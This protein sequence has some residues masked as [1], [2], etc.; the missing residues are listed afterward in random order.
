MEMLLRRLLV[1]VTIALT[2]T[3]CDP[4]TP[5]QTSDTSPT[6]SEQI[7]A[8]WS[9]HIAD[10]PKRWVAA[11]QPMWVRFSHPVA[12]EG[13]LNR[14]IDDLIQ[15]TPKVAITATFTAD[16]E[17]RIAPVGRLPNEQALTFSL[18][19]DKLQDVDP[20]L[21]PFSFEVHT[22]RQDFDLKLDSLAMQDGSEGMMRLTGE[23]HTTDTAEL[24]QVQKLVSVTVNG[25]A[26]ELAWTQ[27]EDRKTNRFML[28]NIARGEQTGK[29]RVEWDGA[30]IGSDSKGARD[31]SLPSRTAFVVTG[32]RVVRAQETYIE[33]NFSAPLNRQQNLA[34]LVTFNQQN[35]QLRVDG[36]SLRVYPNDLPQE[37]TTE[38]VELVISNLVLNAN[39]LALSEEFRQELVLALVQP[40]VNFVGAD[41][42][43]LPPAAQLSVPF[44][45]AGVDSVQVVAFKVYENNIG[46]YLQR[47]RLSASYADQSA[48]RYL[49]RKVY[50]LPDIPRASK[51]RF[52]LD[53]T[54]LMAQHPDGLLRVEL[55]IDR[56]NSVFECAGERPTEPESAA[57]EN[58]EGEDYY[59]REQPPAW[60][61]QYYQSGGYYNYSERTNPCHEAYYYYGNNHITARTFMVSNIGLLAKR[62]TDNVLQVVATGLNDAAPLPGTQIKAFNFQQQVI[63]EGKTDSYGMAEIA[64]DGTPFYLLAEHQKSRG[65]LRLPRNEALPTNQF[66]VSGEHVKA[67]LKGFIYGERDVWRPGD[68]IHLTFILQDREARIPDGHPVR[69]DFFDPRGN[70]ITSQTSVQPVNDF[71]TFTLK[72]NEDSPTG[73]WRAVV[74]V[75]NRFFDKIIKVETI[76]PNR[77]KVELTPAS[78]PLR[79][80]ELPMSVA[81]FGQ[82]LH[83]ATASGLKADSEVKL[84]SRK[85]QF[86]GFQQFVFDDP[87]RTFEGSSQKVFEGKLDREGKAS[88]PLDIT[89]ESPPPGMLTALFNTR[90]FEDSGNFSTALRAFEFHP[91][92]HWVGLQVPKGD[93]YSDAISREAD[94]PVY[95]Q[96]LDRDGKAAAGR[97][98]EVTVHAIGWRWWWDDS[99]DDLASYV[100][101]QH[102]APLSTTKLVT[103]AQGKASWTLTK[104]T[105]D[106]G[107]HL[108]RVC[109]TVSDHCS[110]QVVYLGWSWSEQ[111]NPESATQLMLTTDREK[112][113]VGDTAMVRLPK[114]IE[115]RALLSLE[116]GSRVL[117]RRWVD[118]P[119]GETEL[120]IPIT[121]AMAPNVYVHITLLLP[122]QQ[123]ATDAPMRLY[124]IV[125]LLVEDPA[126]RLQPQL[127]VPEKV[128][129][130]TEF[131]IRVSEE[132]KRA[133]T[134]TLALVDE[135]LLGLT[136]FKVPDAHSHFYRREALG[137]STWDLF[138]QVVGAYGASLE[139]VLAI[140]GSDAEQ[141]ADRQRRERRF[142]PIVK[143]LGT[144][145]LKAGET[146]EHAVTLPPYMGAVRVMLVAA[147]NTRATK[148]SATTYA[149]GKVEQTVTVTQPLVLLATLPRVVGPGEEVRLPVNVFVSEADLK[150]VAI[151]VE[152]NEIFTVLDK[153]AELSFDQPGDAITTLR[154]KVNDR[155]GKG[156]VKITARS[157][158]ESATQE[159]Y[160]DSRAAN[161]PSVVWESKLLDAGEVWQSPLVAHGMAGTNS[162]SVEVSTLPP[163]NLERRLEYLVNYPHGCLEQTTSAAFP[164]LYLGKLLAL[165]D[166]QKRDID[167]HME[168]AVKKLRSLQQSGG[169][170]SY[171]PGD[172]YVNDW[173]S[174]YAGHFLLEAKRAGYAVPADAL[175]NWASYQQQLVRNGGS[176]PVEAETT[177]AAYRL[178]TLALADKAELPAMNRLRERLRA[179]AKQPATAR[180]LLSMTYQHLGLKDAASD[181]LGPLNDTLVSTI[182]TYAN[183]DYTYGSAVR[184]RSLLLLALIRGDAGKDELAWQLAESIATELSSDA[185][186]S[187]QSTAWA[188]LAM[189]EFADATKAG[190]EAMQ[191]SLRETESAPWQNL[192][193][194][195]SLYRQTLASPGVSLRNDSEHKLRVVVS[196]RGTPASLQEDA[197]SNGLQL[198]VSFLTLDNKPLDVQ[199]LP[200]GT[201][202]AAEVTVST[203]FAQLGH[204]RLEDIALTMVMPSGWQIRNERLEGNQQPKGFDYLDIRDDRVLAYFSLWQ[205]HYWQY[206]Y[207]DQSQTSVTLRVILNAS[208]AGKFYLPGWHTSAMY[209]ER[210]QA[211]SKGYWVEVK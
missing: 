32:V 160:I 125:P 167:R 39:R 127:T 197:S 209:D 147:D 109:D 50:R 19:A 170:F 190:A 6:T 173:A 42:G 9:A 78:T 158:E 114:A 144:F 113:Q 132:Q 31:L 179:D 166:E 74:H 99:G 11:E 81:M 89:V 112:Y 159:I 98:L 66:D 38:P 10:Y 41:A 70:K 203:N 96:S 134:Y 126:T 7:S 165:S 133:M 16:N 94:H 163:L 200:Q 13:M 84:L 104:D 181:V 24:E 48:G 117:E 198:Q 191:F 15:V 204:N 183:Q 69:L 3:G 95:F 27:S 36:S 73:N 54:E 211:R 2:L 44:E 188:L 205:N 60:Y 121:Q 100:G 45:A 187:T 61:Q 130:E 71:Y 140:G 107:R 92:N 129:P 35:P 59:A 106:W 21:P 57:P 135:G 12:S 206:R 142:P 201:D 4:K 58:H 154:L 103:D 1:L 64:T 25:T 65:Y 47:N 63:G 87:A 196:N 177:T 75:G 208:Y 193:A 8:E 192:E 30:A 122:H 102:H 111:K 119:A 171:W 202:F 79:A 210:I 184:D 76:T 93:G 136:G 189:S 105:Y 115:G 29:V 143:F 145:T 88:F 116:N 175:D 91:F 20:R 146:R 68:D 18:R 152:A 199:N 52:N 139:R 137:V 43:I 37:K 169:G 86:N 149:Y 97:N 185:W 62:G 174:S 195:H 128:R 34:G 101:G 150:N 14:P 108:I 22:I 82:W 28:E 80:D 17:L 85:T 178:Y 186:Y 67:G 110:G 157:G 176:L 23:L 131:V 120:L 153:T 77:L 180:W 46:Q 26:A 151:S 53:L 148:A 124:G 141:D 72:T 138:D 33:V 118:L 123:R 56:S 194:T 155:V 40:S 5:D 51:Q 83:G 207:R 161:P 182:P 172:A 55:R 164:Q 168:A 162:A 49:W 90:I 156:W